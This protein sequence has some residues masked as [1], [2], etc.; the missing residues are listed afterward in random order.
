MGTVKKEMKSSKLFMINTPKKMQISKNRFSNYYRDS[1]DANS[2]T[3]VT[4][5]MFLKD[6]NDKKDNKDEEEQEKKEIIDL[7]MVL[8]DQ[9][10]SV[11][12]SELNSLSSIGITSKKQQSS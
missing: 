8:A 12:R 10:P 9:V 5:P 4:N 1:T 2:N 7:K 3:P 11:D 6:K